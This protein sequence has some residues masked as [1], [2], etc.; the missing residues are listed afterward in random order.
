M[1]KKTLLSVALVAGSVL[2][3]SNALA[4]LTLDKNPTDIRKVQKEAGDA[5]INSE[6]IL[7]DILV[8]AKKTNELLQKLVDKK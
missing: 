5:A 3:S 2:V 4:V 1:Q 6:K 7:K 8:E